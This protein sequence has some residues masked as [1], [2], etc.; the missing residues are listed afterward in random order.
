MVGKIADHSLLYRNMLS[1][2]ITGIVSGN[3]CHAGFVVIAHSKL[4]VSHESQNRRTLVARQRQRTRDAEAEAEGEN[5]GG[6]DATRL[7]A[8][9][10]HQLL[11]NPRIQPSDALR[12]SGAQKAVSGAVD[13]SCGEDQAE[14]DDGNRHG[15]ALQGLRVAEQHMEVRVRGNSWWPPVYVTLFV[16]ATSRTP[17]EKSRVESFTFYIYLKAKKALT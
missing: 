9:P 4:E 15:V 3:P 6:I 2:L 5:D 11:L 8:L 13:H 14:G 1:L 16:A 10:R 7:C 12:H 17:R